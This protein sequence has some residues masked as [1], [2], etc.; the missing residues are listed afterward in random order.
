MDLATL[1]SK[2][3]QRPG[4]GVPA[5]KRSRT[6]PSALSL[7]P[8]LVECFAYVRNLVKSSGGRA[9]G[10]GGVAPT[11]EIEVR[12]GMLIIKNERRWKETTTTFTEPKVVVP[13]EEQKRGHDIEFKVGVDEIF[14]EHLRVLLGKQGFTA[15][16]EP[17]QRLRVDGHGNRWIVDA[18]GAA[19]TSKI[20]T[21]DRFYRNDFALLSHE[22]DIRI[23]GATESVDSKSLTPEE[24]RQLFNGWTQERIKRRISYRNKDKTTWKIDMTEVESTRRGSANSETEMELEL[25]LEPAAL[26]LWMDGA[27][28]INYDKSKH[29]AKELLGLIN[30]VVPHHLAAPREPE[31]EVVTDECRAQVMRLTELIKAGGGPQA[32]ATTTSKGLEFIGSKPV[33]LLHKNLAAVRRKD[34]FATEKSDGTRYLLYVIDDIQSGQPVAVLMDQSKVIRRMRGG[35]E[36][37]R[38]LGSGTVLDGELV[39]NRSFR[40]TVYLVFDLL[41]LDYKPEVQHRFSVRSDKIHREVMR[42]CQP[43]LDNI[44]KTAAAVVAT[45]AGSSEE[46]P[47]K[48]VR[49]VF[50]PKLE[51]SK[52]IERMVLEDGERVYADPPRRHHKS[53]GVIFQPDA[54]YRFLSDV[55]LLK[56]KW[57]ELMSVDLQAVPVKKD[58]GLVVV[59]KAMGPDNVTVEC[60]KRVN[61]HV[62]LGKFDEYRLLADIAEDSFAGAGHSG[63]SN[64][65]AEVAYDVSIGSWRYLRP[66]K[67]KERAN[68]IDTVLGVFAEMAEAISVEELEY[69]VLQPPGVQSDFHQQLAKMKKQL[70]DWQRDRASKRK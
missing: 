54:P 31:L 14:A 7:F 42:R 34:Y 30:L 21:K 26:R 50:Y 67:D 60:T 33:N 69:A 29:V 57:P 36:L 47:I 32:G 17:E 10:S 3:L 70:L 24:E 18:N 58:G 51:L 64:I 37:G 65:I 22:Y 43:Y 11:T 53:D 52:L 8:T 9:G 63:S 62:G 4:G 12:M 5:S 38:A 15:T 49:K 16:T 25:E 2:S 66:R 39:F 48:V 41:L 40:E 44:E 27:D 19:T 45:A 35:Y 1:A 20:E 23:D 56:W 46:K 55:D 68:H 61:T 28:D 13:T 59:L 6:E